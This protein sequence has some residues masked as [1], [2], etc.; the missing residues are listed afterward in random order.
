MRSDF[1]TCFEETKRLFCPKKITFP[2]IYA[3]A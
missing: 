3:V 2:M 1:L